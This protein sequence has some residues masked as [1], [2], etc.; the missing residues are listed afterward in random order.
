MPN[1]Y[2]LLVASFPDKT[3]NRKDLSNAIQK[4]KKQMIPNKND[5]CQVLTKLYLKKEN[6]PM[7]IVKPQVNPEER[8]LNSL[9]WMAPDQIIAYERYHDVVI[10][11]TT[12][13]TN[14]FD[15]I[16]LLFTVV[17][18]NF[19]NLIVAAAF[20]EDET[21]ATFTWVLQELKNS[22]KVVPTVL[23]SD[24]DLALI[25]AVR[26]N[27]QDTCHIH[28]IFHIHLNLRKKLKGKLHDQFEDFRTKFL[29][30]RN[31]LCHNQFEIGW[32]TLDNEYPEY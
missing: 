25:F 7:W 23:Y 1:Q 26:N 9:F 14:Q 10:V 6:N 21:E 12:S 28:C 13:R 27:Y 5:A 17:D 3:I 16:L 32:N 29:K 15:M 4:F 30:I 11:D 31:S 2:N 24:A 20:L 8:R 19:R 18:N 22:C